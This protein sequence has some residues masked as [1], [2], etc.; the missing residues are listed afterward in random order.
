MDGV[1]FR[2][3]QSKNIKKVAK[4]EVKKKILASESSM[5]CAWNCKEIT[6]HIR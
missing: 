2:K 6:Q 4:E 5:L 1:F 3:W